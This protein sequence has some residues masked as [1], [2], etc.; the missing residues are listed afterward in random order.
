VPKSYVY[1]PELRSANGRLVTEDLKLATADLATSNGRV[2]CARVQATDVR[3]KSSNGRIV[4]EGVSGSVRAKTSNGRIRVITSGIE[5]DVDLELETSNGGVKVITEEHDE[6]GYYVDA[7]TSLGKIRTGLP[8]LVFEEDNRER[9]GH[10]NVKARTVDFEAK[11][12]KVRIGVR[13]SN[14]SISIGVLD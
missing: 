10:K 11:P 9:R 7:H 5:E 8:N 4:L 14:G 2:V 13:T 12:V 6:L 1:R 3:A